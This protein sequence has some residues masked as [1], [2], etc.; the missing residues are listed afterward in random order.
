MQARQHQQQQ[1]QHLQQQQMPA[2]SLQP[3]RNP[4]LIPNGLKVVK[5]SP[6]VNQLGGARAHHQGV[7][8]KSMPGNLASPLINSI[9]TSAPVNSAAAAAAAAALSQRRGNNQAGTRIRRSYS[10]TSQA[11]ALTPK[12]GGQQWIQP[13]QGAA[14]SN[15]S[16]PASL[17]F[18]SGVDLSQGMFSPNSPNFPGSQYPS[19]STTA[20]EIEPG[21]DGSNLRSPIVSPFLPN[22]TPVWFSADANRRLSID[23]SVD[24]IVAGD[25][26]DSET[27][28]G[29]M[30]SESSK[31]RRSNVHMDMNMMKQFSSPIDPAAF[32]SMSFDVNSPGSS[33]SPPPLAG[34]GFISPATGGGAAGAGGNRKPLTPTLSATNIQMKQPG[35]YGSSPI[36]RSPDT[37]SFSPTDSMSSSRE[38]TP[39]PVPVPSSFDSIGQQPVFPLKQMGDHPVDFKDMLTPGPAQ[40]TLANGTGKFEVLTFHQYE[41]PED[42]RKPKANGGD[43]AK[44][45]VQPQPQQQQQS[46]ADTE[47]MAPPLT[48]NA[49]AVDTSAKGVSMV[50]E[51]EEEVMK[52]SLDSGTHSMST[53][54]VSSDN[55]TFDDFGGEPMPLLPG[56]SAPPPPPM[57]MSNFDTLGPDLLMNAD[58][59]LQLQHVGG[60]GNGGDGGLDMIMLDVNA[61]G[62]LDDF[63]GDLAAT[64][65][66][67]F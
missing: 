46:S 27:N 52:S 56:S 38:K 13:K 48:R 40:T 61:A 63:L 67:D 6:M 41:R 42:K 3:P 4:L 39:V 57:F 16:T 25:Y 1:L 30:T 18:G 55:T 36:A 64:H 34:S 66:N 12:F 44:L 5:S 9:P 24:G 62:N 50:K 2:P 22:M 21:D 8:T 20:S 37:A 43:P 65:T 19:P 60:E 15:G 51:E 45:Q 47:K 59:Q 29:S 53:Q 35:K 14:F 31:R 33:G 17:H 26:T 49:S 58:G 32:A 10:S 11:Q 28:V 7:K 23:N 54:T